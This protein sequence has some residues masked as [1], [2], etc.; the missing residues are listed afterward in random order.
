MKTKLE[1]SKGHIVFLIYNII[2]ILVFTISLYFN[3]MDKIKISTIL[4]ILAVYLIS[5]ILLDKFLENKYSI[6]LNYKGYNILVF[7]S[8]I[9]FNIYLHYNKL[10]A[11]ILLMFFYIGIIFQTIYK[12]LKDYNK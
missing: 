1:Y 2:I 12:S 11:L 10:W 7:L 3:I 5:A 6:K 9:V 4:I 8:V